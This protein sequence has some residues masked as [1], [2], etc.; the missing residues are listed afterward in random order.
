S[1]PSASAHVAPSFIPNSRARVENCT[2]V[3]SEV[4][5]RPCVPC[6]V[7]S[8]GFRHSVRPLPEHSMKY[9]RD[10][11]GRR[12]RSAMLNFFGRSVRPCTN[13]KCLAGSIVGRPAWC[14]SK[15]SPEGVRIPSLLPRGVMVHEESLVGFG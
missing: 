10:T 1:A 9:R 8:V 13:R 3:H 15:C 2:P 7:L 4:L 12:L 14:R 6:T 11:E 5:I